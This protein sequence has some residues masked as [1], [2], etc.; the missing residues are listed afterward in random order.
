LLHDIGVNWEYSNLGVGLLGFAL[1]R[2]AGMDFEALVKARIAGPLGMKS[3]AVEVSRGIRKRLAVGHDGRLEPTP[4]LHFPDFMAGAGSL[5]STANDLLT[6]LEAFLG[7]K[8]TPLAAAMSAMLETRRPGADWLA[9]LGGQQALGWWVIGK[10]DDQII[11]HAG[12]TLGFSCSASYNPK[13]RVG[14]VALSNG[15][16]GGEDL[17][18][19]ILRP[20]YPQAKPG[21]QKTHKEIAVDPNLF[22]LYAGKYQVAPNV[23]VVIGREGDKL[24]FMAPGSPRVRLRAEGERDYFIPQSDVQVTFKLDDQGRVTGLILHLYSQY[25]FPGKR[26]NPGPGK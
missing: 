13:T 22:D 6:F 8:K 5:R 18:M 24:W 19:R 17:A 16:S 11:A 14:A 7:I 12:D 3:T 26:L 10:G 4:A 2:R 1:A 21:P 15:V 25:N 23:I 20:S 9:F